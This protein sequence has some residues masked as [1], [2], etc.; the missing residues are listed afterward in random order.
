M[1]LPE[2]TYNI[3]ETGVMPSML[4]SVKVLIGKDDSDYDLNVLVEIV[5]I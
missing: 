1:I 5:G 4:S 2:N 3:D